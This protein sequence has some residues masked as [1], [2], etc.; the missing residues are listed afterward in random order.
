MNI[1]PSNEA[2]FLAGVVDR[3]GTISLYKYKRYRHSVKIRTKE[4][5]ILEKVKEISGVGIIYDGCILDLRRYEIKP[6]LE[7]ILPF[8]KKKKKR[9]Q[10]MLRYLEGNEEKEVLLQEMKE[11]SND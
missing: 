1:V 11:L 2:K 8:L 4:K 10:I 7:E 5:N 3:S 6:F 9:A